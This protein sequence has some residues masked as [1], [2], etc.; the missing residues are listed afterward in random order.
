MTRGSPHRMYLGGNGR[1]GADEHAAQDAPGRERHTGGADERRLAAPLGC[2]E[3]QEETPASCLGG[4]AREE[5]GVEGGWV[6]GKAGC[7]GSGAGGRKAWRLCGL[8]ACA[9][10]VIVARFSRSRRHRRWW[11][12]GGGGGCTRGGRRGASGRFRQALGARPSMGGARRGRLQRRGSQREGGLGR[13]VRARAWPHSIAHGPPV[14]PAVIE[15][16]VE[17]GW[18]LHLTGLNGGAESRPEFKEGNVVVWSVP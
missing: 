7:W 5:W 4:R 3:R 14:A 10:P 9:T 18:V 8:L 6:S 11:S 2:G 16:I 17:V 15:D 12:G 13:G 1:G